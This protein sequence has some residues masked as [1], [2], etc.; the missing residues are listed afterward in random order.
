MT[1]TPLVVTVSLNPAIDRI[2]EVPGFAVGAH[3]HGRLLSR[4]A[5]GKAVNVSRALALL[6]VRNLAAGFVGAGETAF[7]EGSLAGTGVETRFLAVPAATRENITLVDPVARVETHIRDTGFGVGA[8]DGVRLE[9]QLRRTCR[10]GAVVVFSGS[11]PKGITA[12]A[13]GRLLRT[14]IDAKARVVVDTS[15]EALRT[16]VDLPLWLIKPN[17]EELGEI[18]GRPIASEAEIVAAGQRLAERIGMVIVSRGKA[19][20]FCFASGSVLKG[21]IAVDPQRVGNTVGCGDCLLAGCI[22]GRLRSSNGQEAFRYALAVATAKAV[23]LEPGQFD[24]AD[25]EVFFREAV[26]EESRAIS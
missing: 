18:A 8:D 13:F 23:S 24:P 9:E 25:V 11:M 26:V 17:V 7:F 20:A 6:G 15:G 2:I 12:E 5:A 16:A 1:Q 21:C 22:A 10:A 4:T 3:Q 14:C 19:G